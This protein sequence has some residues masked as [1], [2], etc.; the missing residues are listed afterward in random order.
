MAENSLEALDKAFDDILKEFP[1]GRR[2]LVEAAGEKMYRK[3][4]QNID[5]DTK[6]KTGNLRRAVY[7]EIG[8]GGGYAA[9]RNDYKI[10]KHAH[11]IE[12]GHRIMRGAKT[13][14]GKN[15]QPVKIKGSG[16]MIG[17]A[18]GKHVYRNALNGLED[19]L[20]RDAEKMLE[21]TVG[22]AFD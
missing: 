4:L 17:W 6:E 8:S 5:T 14:K 1:E 20:M 18:Q 2:N 12:F 16:K 19:E 3:V 11:L 10:A 7:K 15:G 9:V 13:K 22:D 21:K